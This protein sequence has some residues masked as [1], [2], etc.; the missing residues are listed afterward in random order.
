[1]PRA[2]TRIDLD[3][4]RHTI[5]RPESVI[6][7]QSHRAR[8]ALGENMTDSLAGPAAF[9]EE[10]RKTVRAAAGQGYLRAMTERCLMS[11]NVLAS[12]AIVSAP[13]SPELVREL[14]RLAGGTAAIGLPALSASLRALERAYQE[15]SDSALIDQSW[16]RCRAC[17]QACG[18]ALSAEEF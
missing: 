15:H 6:R 16:Q 2:P 17:V 18:K 7:N 8:E 3:Q 1:M 14:H 13:S 5:K 10:Y 9:D 11:V 4:H 12:G